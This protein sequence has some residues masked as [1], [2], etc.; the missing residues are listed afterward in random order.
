MFDIGLPILL[1]V[2]KESL[3]EG[4]SWVCE[5]RPGRMSV[6]FRQIGLDDGL[7]ILA[8]GVCNVLGD[9]DSKRYAVPYPRGVVDCRG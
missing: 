3:R 5:I 6:R 1:I 2:A 8:E 4:K 9:A 7:A